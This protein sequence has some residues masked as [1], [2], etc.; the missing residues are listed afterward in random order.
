MWWLFYWFYKLKMLLYIFIYYYWNLNSLLTCVFNLTLS[1]LVRASTNK[2]LIG[3]FVFILLQ[4]GEW[5][6]Y[7]FSHVNLNDSIWLSSYIC[8]SKLSLEF[9]L[10]ELCK[11]VISLEVKNRLSAFFW[12]MNWYCYLMFST[13]SS[14]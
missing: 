9:L 5:V 1:C 11:D 7:W 3:I 13:F 2:T 10:S 14:S 4:D 12:E 8:D 6:V